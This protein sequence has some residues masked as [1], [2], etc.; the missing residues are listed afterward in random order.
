MDILD[1][2]RNTIN[3]EQPAA[4]ARE[5]GTF[6]NSRGN[7]SSRTHERR[8]EKLPRRVCSACSSVYSCVFCLLLLA[9]DDIAWRYSVIVSVVTAQRYACGITPFTHLVRAGERATFTIDLREYRYI[10]AA[11]PAN[12]RFSIF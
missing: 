4:Y 10:C 3:Q 1:G 8:G 5:E 12:K 2:R 11:N 9:V 6:R 7:H